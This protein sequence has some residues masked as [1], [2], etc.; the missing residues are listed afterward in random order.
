MIGNLPAALLLLLLLSSCTSVYSNFCSWSKSCD[1]SATFQKRCA[2]LKLEDGLTKK[3]LHHTALPEMKRGTRTYQKKKAPL[4]NKLR[5]NDNKAVRILT[6]QS[7]L[8]I[9]KQY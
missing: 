4:E 1:K 6:H 3:V 2:R 7:R 9:P 5:T 8:N